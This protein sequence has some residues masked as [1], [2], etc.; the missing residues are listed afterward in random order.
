MIYRVSY[1]DR[2]EL[3]HGLRFVPRHEFEVQAQPR[4]TR[5]VLHLTSALLRRTTM[6]QRSSRRLLPALRYNH[7]VLRSYST[8]T[9][10]PVPANNP[11]PE[12]SKNDFKVSSTNVLPSSSTGASDKPLVELPEEGEEKRVMQAPNRATTW[13]RSQQPRATAMVGPRFEQTIMEDQVCVQFAL[14]VEQR[15]VRLY[16]RVN[17]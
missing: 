16:R 2:D 12:V 6:L 17:G 5:Y 15:G 13:S 9:D 8:T 7:A 14:D 3:A 11:K 10:N 4:C 1:G